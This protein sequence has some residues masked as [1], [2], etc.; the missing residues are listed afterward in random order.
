[1]NIVKFQDIKLIH[2]KFLAFLY[3][4]DE[5]TENLREQSHSPLQQEE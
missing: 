3:I 4:K 2:Q 1:M 5:K